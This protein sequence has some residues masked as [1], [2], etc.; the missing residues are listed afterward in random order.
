MFD[1]LQISGSVVAIVAAVVT[2]LYAIGAWLT[3]VQKRKK[4]RDHE[5]RR[6]AMQQAIAHLEMDIKHLYDAF[7]EAKLPEKQAIEVHSFNARLDKIESDFRELR[8]LL[9][10]NPEAAVS[11]PLIKKD[12]D[13]LRRDNENV[14]N[15]LD[16]LGGFYKWFIGIMIT[17]SV[18]LLGLAVSILLKP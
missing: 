13:S 3:S 17:M 18:G 12:I 1:V 4:A 9:F 15:E 5:V 10:D 2:I 7:K 8:R 14:R 16:R 11:V 6:P